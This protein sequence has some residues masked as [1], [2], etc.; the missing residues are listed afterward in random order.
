MTM[1]ARGGFFNTS[2]YGGPGWS[3]R[4]AS[5]RE[6]IG[7]LWTSSGINSEW[8]T[9]RAVLL[10]RPGEE[11]EAS[12]SDPDSVQMLGPVDFA[13]ARDQHDT[14]AEA[15]LRH[16]ITVHY[17][18]P[19]G[20]PSSNQMFCADLLFLTPEGAIVARPAST[21]RAGE[22]RQ[23]ARRLANIGVPIVRTMR[24]YAT[25]EG[26][27]A[28][29]IDPGLVMIGKGLRTNSEAVHQIGNALFEM[30][31]ETVAVDLPF[32]TMHFMGL[33][34]IVDS[35]L[36]LCWWRRTPFVAVR[37]LQDRGLKIVWLPEGDEM[38]VG[39]AFNFVTLGPRKIL[40]AAGYKEV[41]KAFE[42]AGSECVTVDCSELVKAA[43]AIGCLTAVIEREAVV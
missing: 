28:M 13:K 19:D 15:Y 23:I 39:R 10:H 12:S 41:D 17:V 2:A 36:A 30:D 43:G 6:E 35:D 25:F 32:G 33:L 37:A 8:G 16:G 7:S 42:G 3:G 18:E 22:E 20:I 34:R 4:V 40:M 21:V 31:V 29:W 9:L 26:A 14:M 27:D 38:D 24:G 11:L 1:S 5:H